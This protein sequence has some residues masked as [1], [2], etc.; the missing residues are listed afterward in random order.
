[1]NSQ[2][3]LCINEF[4]DIISLQKGISEFKKII[5]DIE[6]YKLYLGKLVYCDNTYIIILYAKFSNHYCTIL[7]TLNIIQ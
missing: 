1:M 3:K 7:I 2:K 4:V 5:T 6:C